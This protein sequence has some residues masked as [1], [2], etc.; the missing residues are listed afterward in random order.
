MRRVPLVMGVGDQLYPTLTVEMLR[1]VADAM[2]PDA[3]INTLPIRT[4]RDGIGSIVVPE[5]FEIPTDGQ[6]RAW[7]NFGPPGGSRYVSARAVLDGTVGRARLEGR[8]V[9]VGT[10]AVGLKDVKPTPVSSAM[11]GV[12]VHA[13]LLETILANGYLHRPSYA[14]AVELT[15]LAGICL[16]MMATV[17]WLGPIGGLVAGAATIGGALAT[18]WYFYVEHSLLISVTNAALAGFVLYTTLTVLNFVRNDAEKRRVRTAF[19]RYLSPDLVKELAQ[20][21]DRL[22]L[23]G[24]MRDMTILFCDIRGFTSISE[25][26]RSDPRGLTDFMNRYLTPL[27]HRALDR[28]GTIDKYMGDCIMAFWNA[29]LDDPDHAANAC[30]AACDMLEAIDELNATLKR[31]AEAE[32]R[33]YLPIRMGFGINS[34]ICCVGNMGSDLRFD[35]SV[36]GDT[37]NLASRLEGQSKTYGVEVVAGEGTRARAPGCAWIELDLI[38]V[39]GKQEAERIFALAGGADVAADPAFRTV[40]DICRRLL[41]SYRACDWD[42]GEQA[43]DELR[44]HPGCARFGLNAFGELFA[45]RIA[46]FRAEPPPEG[47]DGVFVATEK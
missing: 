9:L 32:G 40:S 17:A 3:R 30:A 36:I 16:L 23:G 45:A 34:G 29:P 4:H 22:H 18:S 20:N 6:G 8:F 31:E 46:A 5:L 38:R 35:Y 7:V 24:E 11:P 42:A 39:K 10:S 47:W 26:Y 43:A 15:L 14:V 41:A 44:A 33:P 2:V 27:T 13:Q 21:S 1:V 12:E 28:H 19:S 37:V 25:Q